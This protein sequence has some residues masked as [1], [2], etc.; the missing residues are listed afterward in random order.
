MKK[1]TR[2]PRIPVVMSC[3]A[4]GCAMGFVA[5]FV[6]V[7]FVAAGTW[8]GAPVGGGSTCAGG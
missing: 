8:T 6:A 7:G 4:G 1:N 2:M 3:E 5:G